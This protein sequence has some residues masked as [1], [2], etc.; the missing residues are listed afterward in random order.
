MYLTL[1]SSTIMDICKI[2][3]SLARHLVLFSIL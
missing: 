3:V 2:Q 1:K